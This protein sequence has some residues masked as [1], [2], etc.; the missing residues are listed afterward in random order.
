MQLQASAA[1]QQ[2]C[3]NLAVV[4]NTSNMAS[5]TLSVFYQVNNDV[6]NKPDSFKLRHEPQTSSE[7]IADHFRHDKRSST[8]MDHFYATTYQRDF[9]GN[10]DMTSS[11]PVSSKPVYQGHLGIYNH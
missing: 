5:S 11:H 3:L 8:Y 2:F 9:S 10:E 4:K 6:I 7:P 1:S